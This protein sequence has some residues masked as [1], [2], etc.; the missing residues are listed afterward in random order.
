[1]I[2]ILPP[3]GTYKYDTWRILLVKY[4][5]DNFVIFAEL[6]MKYQQAFLAPLQGRKPI[7]F[8]CL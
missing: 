4:Y 5:I 6:H 3:L 1:M 7:S 8:I 2:E